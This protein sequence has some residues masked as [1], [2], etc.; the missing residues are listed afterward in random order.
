[1]GYAKRYLLACALV[2]VLIA[3]GLPPASPQG[4]GVEPPGAVLPGAGGNAT[5]GLPVINHSYV[6]DAH[7]SVTGGGAETRVLRRATS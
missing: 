4:A 2:A 1:M 7:L 6:L 5:F 3:S